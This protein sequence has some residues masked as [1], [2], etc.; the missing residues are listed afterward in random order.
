[1][2]AYRRREAAA[3]RSRSTGQRTASVDREA[4]VTT[5]RRTSNGRSTIRC[6]VSGR[7]LAG[8][9][10]SRD[11][12]TVRPGSLA[13]LADTGWAPALGRSATQLRRRRLRVSTRWKRRDGRQRQAV[14][15][16]GG[17]RHA[18]SSSTTTR[19]PTTTPPRLAPLLSAPCRPTPPCW[20]RLLNSIASP[21]AYLSATDA[22]G[23]DWY[24]VSRPTPA[25]RGDQPPQG[26]GS[27]CAARHPGL[28]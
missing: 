27:P 2:L 14:K 11:D 18:R 28:I 23:A 1:M 5:W 20:P 8:S 21:S 4:K 6:S 7:R 10:R 24:C 17:S 26:Q 22:E 3:P 19:L 12:Q 16:G 9:V 13:T 15:R 25:D